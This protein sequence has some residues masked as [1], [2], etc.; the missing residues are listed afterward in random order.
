L[1]IIKAAQ[2]LSGVRFSYNNALYE[3]GPA[4][5]IDGD[6][7]TVPISPTVRELIPSGSDLEFDA[8]TC[9]CHLADDRGM[10]V[11]QDAV[12]KAVRP[13]VSFI[14]ATDYWN[15]LALGLV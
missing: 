4:I 1:R 13:N 10:D 7:W 2:D 11:S 3:T 9:L 15:D 8:P 14:E 5:D 12:G 6:V